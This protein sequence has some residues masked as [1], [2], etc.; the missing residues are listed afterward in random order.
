MYIYLCLSVVCLNDH[1]LESEED[2]HHQ[3]LKENGETCHRATLLRMHLP[4]L[5]L[6]EHLDI[7]RERREGEREEGER[8]GE[9]EREE[10]ER[11]GEGGGREGRRREGGGDET[12]KEEREDKIK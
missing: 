12:E 4:V 5:A 10:R 3:V 1:L 6:V 8:E 2:L 11:E 7:W 9:R